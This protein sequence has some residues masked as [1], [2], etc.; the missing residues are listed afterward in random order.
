[1]NVNG[2]DGFDQ[3]IERELARVASGFEGANPSAAQ[4]AYHVAFASGGSTVSIF[5]S[6]TAALT[7]KAAIAATAATLV[8]GGSAAAG[9][10]TAGPNPATWGSQV[11]QTVKDCKHAVRVG[12]G[13]ATAPENVGQCVSSFAKK[14]GA[15]KRVEHATDSRPKHHERKPAATATDKQADADSAAGTDKHSNNGHHAKADEV[16]AGTHQTGPSPHR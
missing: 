4:S 15:D 8:V 14:H 1:M 16:A 2:G 12:S 11:V 6:I 13:T 3:L 10:A 7:T 5:S 9:V